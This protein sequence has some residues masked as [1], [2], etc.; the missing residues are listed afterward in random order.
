MMKMKLAKNIIGIFILVLLIILPKG[1]AQYSI[2]E[3]FIG[4]KQ[5]PIGIKSNGKIININA[6]IANT[7]NKRKQGLMH[8]ESMPDDVGMLFIFDPPRMVSMWMKNT[9][10]E[11]DIIFID[12]DQK[13]IKI[14]KNAQP[15]SLESISSGLAVKWVVEINGKASDLWEI[16]PGDQLIFQ[17]AD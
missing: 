8:V 2:N 6:Y 10:I 16:K 3:R 4:W 13:I 11:L 12:Q 1:E 17:Q 5:Q 7:Q 9:L 14:H 15:Y